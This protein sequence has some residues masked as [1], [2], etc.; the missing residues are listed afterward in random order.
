MKYAICNETFE[1]QPFDEAWAIAR[2]LGYTGI[3]IA[4]FTLLPDAE[5]FDVRD[6]PAAKRDEVK[7]QAANAGLEVVGLHWILAKS[8]GPYLT[9]P[10][11]AVRAATVE[12]FKAVSQL[13]ADLGG[14]VMV[15]GSPLQRNLLPG[16]TYDE[17]EQHAA[18]VLRALTP[19]L[20]DLNLTLAL[21]PL[22]PTEGDFLPTAE[23]GIR[24]AQMVD[25]PHCQ[26][27]LDVKA[28]SSESKSIP[29]IIRDS[30]QWIAHFH[31][32]DPNLSG[33]GMG[34]MDFGPIFAALKEVAYDGWVS[35]EVFNY[36]PSP[37]EI[38]QQSI[39]YMQKIWADLT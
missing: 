29:D 22:A 37:K 15:L 11:K 38:S 17:A 7:Q 31:A 13:C 27:H 5:I 39:D 32:N 36:K 34:E 21:E 25:S 1:N 6:V 4:P 28:M 23:S 14:K 16:V 9:S 24:L 20:A 10:D 19:T 12:Y 33:P 30:A 2:D 26:L 3:E 18:E 8:K 35:V